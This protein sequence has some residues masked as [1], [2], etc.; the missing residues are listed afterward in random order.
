MSAK[1]ADRG[2]L[3]VALNEVFRVTDV[4][5]DS[6]WLN[7]DFMCDFWLHSR[8]LRRLVQVIGLLATTLLLFLSLNLFM[9]C[10]W[11]DDDRCI[12]LLLGLL[13]S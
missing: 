2:S 8:F 10:L 6:K 3:L 4:H 13:L 11:R 9:E 12:L 5:R 7:F 1:D